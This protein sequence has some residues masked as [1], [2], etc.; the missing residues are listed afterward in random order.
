MFDGNSDSYIRDTIFDGM[1]YFKIKR[2][3]SNGFEADKFMLK[4]STSYNYNINQDIRFAVNDEV[5]IFTFYRN[6]DG[7]IESKQGLRRTLDGWFLQTSV[8]VLLLSG[9]IAFF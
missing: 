2:T 3:G 4:N 8:S 9:V 6:V 1:E 5:D 7:S